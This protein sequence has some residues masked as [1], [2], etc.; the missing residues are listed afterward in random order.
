MLLLYVKLLGQSKTFPKSKLGSHQFMV[1]SPEVNSP[2]TDL[3]PKGFTN[4]GSAKIN[5]EIRKL[6]Q[7]YDLGRRFLC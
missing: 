1:N 2:K 4:F 6:K 3:E 5:Q 7:V